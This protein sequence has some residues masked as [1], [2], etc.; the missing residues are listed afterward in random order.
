MLLL[1]R[2]SMEKNPLS[3]SSLK[4]YMVIVED[5][6]EYL[7]ETKSA[8]EEKMPGHAV[9]TA[10]D[11]V[12]AVA[13]LHTLDR[14]AVFVVDYDLPD[15][16]SRTLVDY[17]GK[18]FRFPS[19]SYFLFGQESEEVIADALRKEC[20]LPLRKF[21]PG[22]MKYDHGELFF[23]HLAYGLHKA[24]SAIKMQLDPLTGLFT[25]QRAFET[26]KH[27]YI[28]AKRE[29]E[30]IGCIMIDID[31]LGRINKAFGHDVGDKVIVNIAHAFQKHTRTNFDTLVRWGG[32]EFI[33]ILPGATRDGLG[34]VETRMM[35]DV[36]AISIPLDKKKILHPT[37]SIGS[38]VLVP[39]HL[40]SNPEFAWERLTKSADRD[41]LKNK[42]ANKERRQQQD[43][44]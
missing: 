35:V 19:F 22:S 31:D 10:S 21:M 13:L 37:I 6:K 24:G 33:A 20:V 38:S 2:P 5:D 16:P 39:D 28:R 18:T 15:M 32:D 4:P 7:A 30:S 29:R 3:E 43:L 40:G 17:I 44:F 8:I 27:D 23:S 1:G 11:P 26:W 34:K 9:W 14:P 12:H 41:M 36:G 42:A 25:R